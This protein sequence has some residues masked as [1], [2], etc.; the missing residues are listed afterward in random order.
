LTGKPGANSAKTAAILVRVIALC[1]LSAHICPQEPELF[2]SEQ[3][4]S[5][6][7]VCGCLFWP[8][9]GVWYQH[10]E[11][12]LEI[13]LSLLLIGPGG[14]QPEC[15]LL[16]SPLLLGA[17]CLSIPSTDQTKLPCTCPCRPA[18]CRKFIS[19]AVCVVNAFH[20]AFPKNRKHQRKALTTQKAY[21][22]PAGRLCSLRA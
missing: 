15:F 14:P 11:P 22:L 16:L 19:S 4:N 3:H 13:R 12:L 8:A 5:S 1:P 18:A 9:T 20:A 21:D 2:T 17:W 7:G 10:R 6:S